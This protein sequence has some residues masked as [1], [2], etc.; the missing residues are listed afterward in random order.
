[1]IVQNRASQAKRAN[2]IWSQ[3]K[4]GDTATI[5]RVCAQRDL[6][7]F[8]HMSGNR[9]PLM[10]PSEEDK[11]AGSEPI[12]PS[13]WVGSLISTVLGNILPGPG[14]L[15]RSQTFEFAKRVHIGDRLR[16]TVT[17]RE[18]REEP[19]A[20]FE[21]VITDVKGEIRLQGH[22]G[23]RGAAHARRDRAARP[24]DADSRRE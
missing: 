21:T 20:L 6:L 8:A 12:A 1:M 17:C 15:Y 23:G 16:V 19:V 9:N 22:G 10:L 5:E 14:T 24:A 2:T 11:A 18:K 13:M 4:V 7:L 3:L